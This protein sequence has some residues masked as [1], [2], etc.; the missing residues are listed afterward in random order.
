MPR[1]PDILYQRYQH[2]LEEELRETFVNQEGLLYNMLV[3]QLGWKDEHGTPQ[4][5]GSGERYHASLCLLAC[6]SLL[7][8]YEPALPAGAAVELVHNFSLIHEDV[9][10]GSPSRGLRPSI[11]WIWGPGQAINAGDGMHALAR[12]AL[13][14]LEA[15][16]VNG[17]KI[18]EAMRLLDQACLRM[19]E[20]Q[21][22]DLAFQERLDVGV[23]SYL[24]MAE[25][26]AGAL[27][28]CA[29]G[30]GALVANGDPDV[31]RA[32][33][34]CGKNLGI[35]SQ[36]TDDVKEIVEGSADDLVSSNLLL[37]KKVLPVV[38]GLTA[39]EPATRRTL[40]T[41]YLKRVLEPP[42]VPQV[43]RILKD[44]GALEHAS[45]KADEYRNAAFRSLE[46]VT[47]SDWGRD[48][49]ATLCGMASEPKGQQ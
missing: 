5:T 6:E 49:L 46:D 21:Y 45:E 14:R 36:I 7:A 24:K 42:D 10:S 23:E 26:K 27:T 38:Y 40:G 20:G 31:V 4:S 19:C 15:R 18:L 32:F 3:F 9:H 1:L 22:L 16:G 29:M 8:E 11:W 41:I 35:A 34:E 37:K 2:A 44:S 30:L 43:V 25:G 47:L 33:T 13:M 17:A 12:L 39:G 48:Q 28:S